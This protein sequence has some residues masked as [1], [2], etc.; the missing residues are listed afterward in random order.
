[1]PE[2]M[3]HLLGACPHAA[4]NSINCSPHHLTRR[5]GLFIQCHERIDVSS[6]QCVGVNPDN[7]LVLNFISV[8]NQGS[9]DLLL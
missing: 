5:N 2:I 1:M 4:V 7:K 8:C 9:A 6:L 3:S